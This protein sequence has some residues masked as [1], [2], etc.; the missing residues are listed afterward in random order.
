M[1]F[2]MT[3]SVDGYYVQYSIQETTPNSVQSIVVGAVGASASTKPSC[4]PPP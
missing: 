4:P 1:S 2:E 3:V